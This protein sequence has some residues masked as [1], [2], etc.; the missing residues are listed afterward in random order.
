MANELLEYVGKGFFES[1]DKRLIG[2]RWHPGESISVTTE[3]LSGDQP[4]WK[5]VVH[6]KRLSEDEV[7]FFYG[8]MSFITAVN[9]I[10]D[11]DLNNIKSLIIQEE[12]LELNN[13]SFEYLCSAGKLQEIFLAEERHTITSLPIPHLR[14]L[15][16]LFICGDKHVKI[17]DDDLLRLISLEVLILSHNDYITIRG[18]VN[19]PALQRVIL[20][21]N[22]KI[23]DFDKEIIK[24]IKPYLLLLTYDEESCPTDY[25]APLE[26]L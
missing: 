25:F 10:S 19:H 17:T 2:Q 8:G 18:I 26:S 22:T 4:N 16:Y 6:I 20:Y 12:S 23:T 24:S 15:R 14:N 3:L 21:T 7:L 11:T 9:L 1:K 13:Q 5:S